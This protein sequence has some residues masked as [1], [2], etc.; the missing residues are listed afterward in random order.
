MQRYTDE[1]LTAFLQYKDLPYELKPVYRASLDNLSRVYF[2][3]EYVKAAFA[4]DIL[5]ENNRTY[6]E[7]L[8]SCKFIVSPKEPV[9]TRLGLISIGKKPRD[10]IGGAY[11]QFLRV[12]GNDPMGGIID[13]EVI[14]GNISHIYERSEMRFKNYNKRAYDILS[15][16]KAKVTIDYPLTAF[17]QIM[18]NALCHRMYEETNAPIHFYMYN[19]YFE[20]TS[21]GGPYGTVTVDNFG[22]QGIISYRNE[23]LAEVMKNLN[24]IQHFGYG[25]YA[26][27]KAMAENGNPPIQFIVSNSHVRVILWRRGVTPCTIPV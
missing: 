11:V 19:D 22:E 18:C 6:E 12:D 25:I 16:S 24:L 17:S 3:E 1:E 8:A 2:E 27:K 10:F 20:I 21:P 26:A 13:E 15:D 5:R 4:D 7:R 23:N 9:P 14:E